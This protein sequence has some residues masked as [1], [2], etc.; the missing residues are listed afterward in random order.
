MHDEYIKYL[1]IYNPEDSL[2]EEGGEDQDFFCLLSGS[3]GI[4]KGDVKDKAK[5]VKVGDI[6]EPGTYFGEMSCLLG[7]PRTASILAVD[8]VKT[9]KF[10]GNMLPQMILKQPK[11]GLKVCTDLAERL[12]GTT[13]KQQNIMVERNEL[14]NDSTEQFLRGKASFQKVFIMLTAL[15]SQLQHP[16]LKTIIEQMSRDPL[17]QGGR[18]LHFD[19]TF[20]ADIPEPLV[21][22]IKKAYAGIID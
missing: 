13:N 8:K 7:E 17:L 6:T 9:L 21:E 14:R 11:L 1:K 16:L 5:R 4:W 15:Q 3:V 12:K 20:F 2:I 19:Q 10:P 18:K 22:A